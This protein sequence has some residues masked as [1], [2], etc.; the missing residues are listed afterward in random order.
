MSGKLAEL[1]LA[2][3]SDAELDEEELEE[4]TR[5][6]REELLE[7]DVE[8]VDF[9]KAGELPVGAK[10]GDPVTWGQLLIALM[11]SGGA[12]TTLITCIQSWLA[13]SDRRSVTLEIDGD[14]LE[15]T[16]ISSKEQQELVDRWINRHPGVL[17][18][19]G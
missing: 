5:Q 7:L 1:K 17:L 15:V 9:V 2:I 13:R 11:A 6:L 16:G 14:K 18:A 8:T 3:E 10:A 19:R 4:L 12:I